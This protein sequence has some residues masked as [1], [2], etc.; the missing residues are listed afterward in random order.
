ML[1][2]FKEMVRK[3]VEELKNIDIMRKF[4]E[5]EKKR[6]AELEDEKLRLEME[7]ISAQKEM[8]KFKTNKL[9]NTLNTIVTFEHRR[10]TKQFF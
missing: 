4:Q 8:K 10:K 6:K 7:K 1:I 5:K 9:F 3:E 2:K